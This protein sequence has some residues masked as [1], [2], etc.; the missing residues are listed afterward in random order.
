MLK[1][2][3]HKI[4]ILWHKYLFL[5]EEEAKLTK[6][7]KI[8]NM[9]M[10]DND[11]EKIIAARKLFSEDIMLILNSAK[12]KNHMMKETDWAIILKSRTCVIRIHFTIMIKHMIKNAISQTN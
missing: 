10:K 4:T 3:E 2:I 11:K 6:I 12:T 7:V 8:M 1:Q 5:D 9:K